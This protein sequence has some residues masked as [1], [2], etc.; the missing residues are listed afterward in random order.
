MISVMLPCLWQ[1]CPL[2]PNNPEVSLNEMRSPSEVLSFEEF[3][4]CMDYRIGTGAP[5]LHV[6][7]PAFDYVSPE[8]VSLFITDM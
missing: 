3:S 1:F 2:Y 5:Q 6:V 4:D 7:N 8:L